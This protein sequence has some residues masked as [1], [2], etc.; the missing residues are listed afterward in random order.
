MISL[1]E[2]L[3][4]YFILNRLFFCLLSAFYWGFI[5]VSLA[6]VDNLFN[7]GSKMYSGAARMISIVFCFC[8]YFILYRYRDMW[9]DLVF[10]SF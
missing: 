2:T 4:I 5:M 8:V 3:F 6:S 9:H 1:E 7:L 10:F